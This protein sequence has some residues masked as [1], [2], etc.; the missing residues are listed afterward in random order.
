[1]N[2]SVFIHMRDIQSLAIE[3]F[4]DSRNQSPPIMNDILH[5]RIILS[6]T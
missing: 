3:M 2:V 5:K 6:I 1:M 4:R